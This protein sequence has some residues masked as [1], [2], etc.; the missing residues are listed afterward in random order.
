MHLGA[1]GV[2]VF[3][4]A[5]DRTVLST[6]I[7]KQGRRRFGLVFRGFR[8]AGFILNPLINPTFLIVGLIA[9][10]EAPQNGRGF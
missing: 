9:R 1:V 6:P 5:I 10:G 2:G 7:A 3:D 8:R 4:S